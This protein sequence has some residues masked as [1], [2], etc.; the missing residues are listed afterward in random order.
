MKSLAVIT[1]LAAFSV[2]AAAAPETAP[3]HTITATGT[4]KV[5]ATPDTAEVTLQVVS[6]G[7]TADAALRE[8]RAAITNLLRC[9]AEHGVSP[10]DAQ[11]STPRIYPQYDPPFSD[12]GSPELAGYQA[13]TEVRVT[14]RR[15]DRLGRVI[16]DA[17]GAGAGLVGKP[18]YSVTDENALKAEARRKALADARRKAEQDAR[19]AGMKLGEVLRIKDEKPS[20]SD[21]G[22]SYG[23]TTAPEKQEFRARVVVTYAAGKPSREVETKPPPSDKKR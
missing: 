9:L 5:K 4:A 7:V 10:K 20:D 13:C 18:E 19:A 2:G 8:N 6:Q 1:L 11:P 16:D 15:L 3:D 12:V 22:D 21:S 17:A 23:K 14:V